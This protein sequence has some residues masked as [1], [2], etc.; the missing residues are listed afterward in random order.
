MNENLQI[1][2]YA[3]AHSKTL[4][5]LMQL[6]VPE[7]FAAS[8]IVDYKQY[9]ENDIEKYFVAELSGEIIGAGGINFEDDYSTGI[10]SWDFIHPKFQGFGIGSKLLIYRLELLKSMKNIKNISVRTSQ[11][12]YKFYEKNGFVLQNIQKDYW[13]KGF[14]MYKMLYDYN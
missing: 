4:V 5:E 10:I 7:Y 8:E 1:K 12:T 11:L 14:D 2:P 6:N 13:A 9:L 3:V